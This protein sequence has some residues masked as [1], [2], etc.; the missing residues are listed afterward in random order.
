M[1]E[2]VIQQRVR[3]AQPVFADRYAAGGELAKLIGREN[4]PG[5]IVLPLPR[6][7][8][9]VGHALA[10]NLGCPLI[11]V[12]ARKLPVPGSPEMGFGAVAIDGSM[13]LNRPLVDSMGLG[14]EEIQSIADKVTREI[15]R[16]A[17]E[18]VG[19]DQPPN[20]EGRIAYMVDD[21]L[22]TGY[23]MIAAAKM[24]RKQNPQKL[25][26]AVPVTPER[27]LAPVA[28]FFDESYCVFVQ[29]TPRFAVASFYQNFQ[30]MTDR[31]VQHILEQHRRR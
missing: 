19:S 28:E 7:G 10:E 24:V 17:E 6:G 4:E 27:S 1:A 14:D 31:E 2:L 22:A 15:R 25:V 13:E 21:G 3:N 16:R 20:V 11:P 26:L 8:I 12:I 9:P 29:L 18:Y 5:S 30:D 23:T